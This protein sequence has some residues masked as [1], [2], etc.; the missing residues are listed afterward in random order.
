[1]A[2]VV[3]YILQNQ[4][5]F[6]HKKYCL[7]TIIFPDKL[8]AFNNPKPTLVITPGWGTMD[9]WTIDLSASFIPFSVQ[10]Q[11][12]FCRY[13]QEKDKQGGPWEVFSND[14]FSLLFRGT[15]TFFLYFFCKNNVFFLFFLKKVFNCPTIWDKL[16]LNLHQKSL[17]N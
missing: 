13:R 7:N 1:M 11:S 3:F 9:K 2:D 14:D 15:M 10:K 8:R 12:N 17:I 6:W 5:Y 16:L 4:P